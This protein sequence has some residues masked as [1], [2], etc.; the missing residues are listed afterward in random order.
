MAV[1]KKSTSALSYQLVDDSDDK[2]LKNITSNKNNVHY[3][4]LLIEFPLLTILDQ[5]HMRDNCILSLIK[6]IL[7]IDFSAETFIN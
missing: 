3:K 7:L 1:Q 4:L 5:D 2:L 6:E